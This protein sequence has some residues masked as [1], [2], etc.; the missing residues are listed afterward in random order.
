MLIRLANLKKKKK[1]QVLVQMWN[2]LNLSILLRDS[3]KY[4]HLENCWKYLLRQN[5]KH[6][7]FPLLGKYPL[8]ESINM[9]IKRHVQEFVN[10][11]AI[12]K[13]SKTKNTNVH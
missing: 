13:E 2:N 9:H 10:M 12:L 7:E 11:R 5:L 1:R 4:H 3:E 8:Q 6:P